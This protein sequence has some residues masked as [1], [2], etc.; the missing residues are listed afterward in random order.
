MGG[1]D[2]R[3]APAYWEDTDLAFRARAEGRR[4]LYQ[5]RSV[6]IHHE[7]VS[8]GKE[9]D[10]GL[11]RHQLAN[12]HTFRER[13]REVLDQEHGEAS[14]HTLRSQDRFGRR[15][16][17]VVDHHLPEPDR[18]AG[19]RSMWCVLRALVE[20]GLAVKF[21]PQDGSYRAEYATPL[22]QLGIEVLVGDEL[23]DR[24]SDWLMANA[25]RLDYVLLSR[26][27]VASEFLPAVRQY[28]RAKVLFYGHDVHHARLFAEHAATGSTTALREAETMKELEEGLWRNVDV[29]YYPSITETATVRANL[30]DVQAYTL[31]LC[32]F[33]EQPVEV[34]PGGRE[35]I[36][37]VAGFGHPPNVDAAIW[38]V[39][40]VLPLLVA[41]LG[42]SVSVRLVGSS[43]T[44][45]VLRLAGDNV[46]V[47]GYVSDA[48]LLAC[49]GRARA[50][51]VPLRFG[52]GVKGKVLE[53]L[54]HGVPLVT[55][56]TGAQGLE[57]LEAVVPVSDDAGQIAEALVTLLQDD[58][59]WRDASRRQLDYMAGR[60]SLE[61]MQQALRFGMQTHG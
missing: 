29:V 28:S 52:A 27:T 12:Q 23:R 14:F 50:A 20:Q 1:F 9:V 6:V 41:R 35:G 58:G 3:Y 7:G 16:I 60:F 51:V 21:W 38:L 39:R 56:S 54:H 10:E 34:E 37:F 18:D 19:S 48:E 5:P 31:P 57:G 26:P 46:T 2:E 15:T 45:E 36:L 53:A 33:D 49:Y 24:F 25:G 55:T 11:K 22:E 17:L 40:T 44:E 4:V 61:A 59:A 42:R 30:P 32:F 13:W 43:P 47:T 8:H